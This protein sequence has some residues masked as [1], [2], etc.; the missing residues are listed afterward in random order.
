[1]LKHILV[2]TCMLFCV[3]TLVKAQTPCEDGMAGIYPCENVDLL[4]VISPQDLGSV[5]DVN[6]LWGWTD[7]ESGREFA[8]V[9]V[10]NGLTFVEIT[11]PI[12]PVVIGMLP[13]ATSN[14]L[15]RDVKVYSDYAFIA[16]EADDHG[17]QVFNLN[18]LL[19]DNNGSIVT[20]E[21][22]AHYGSFGKSHNIVI[23]EESGFAYS[24]G[25]ETFSGGVHFVDISDPLNPEIAGGFSADGYTHDAQVVIY[26]GPDA[27]YAGREIAFCS[28]E[29]EI[30]IVDVTDKDDPNLISVTGYELSSYTHQGWLTDDWNYFIF[31]DEADENDGLSS[32]TKTFFLDIK[33]L[34][35]PILHH[36]FISDVTASD[37]NLYNK[38]SLCYQSNFTSGLRILDIGN[39]PEKDISSLAY[40]DSQPN[41]NTVGLRGSWSNYAYFPSGNLILSD[42]SSGFFVL[43]PKLVNAYRYTE[44]CQNASSAEFYVDITDGDISEIVNVEALPE[45]MSIVI[46][47]LESPGQIPITINFSDEL[48]IGEY[49]IPVAVYNGEDVLLSEELKIVVIEGNIPAFSGFLPASGFQSY[50][51]TV[52]L[53]WDEISNASS[54]R[55]MI[56][57]TDDFSTL[58]V[59]EELTDNSYSFDDLGT[60]YWKVSVVNNCGILYE[61]DTNSFSISVMSVE[62]HHTSIKIFPNPAN[63]YLVIEGMIGEVEIISLD[64]RKIKSA[65]IQERTELNISDLATGS[66]YLF[67]IEEGVY[68]RFVKH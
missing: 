45:N 20:F 64:G 62:E 42:M 48:E 39:I 3:A 51:E 40:F 23:N 55:L 36:E 14:S 49:I 22:D 2:I 57:N 17:M 61:S 29:D 33:N 26:N 25:T 63:D 60:Y 68:S 15:W 43:R 67:S 7:Q 34:D 19:P 9:G 59:D 66:Y 38:G 32:T 10:R 54:Y 12:N 13:T 16:S 5:Q 1:M 11:D 8:L 50:E 28:N 27:D 35:N 58:I 4:S 37:H 46:G 52:E 30:T 6:D 65:L 24:V 56:S 44:V 41:D 53:I 31:N 47:E 18:N 21:S